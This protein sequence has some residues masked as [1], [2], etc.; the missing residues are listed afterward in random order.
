MISVAS[1]MKQYFMCE[2]KMQFE[3]FGYQFSKLENVANT[4]L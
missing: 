2:S 4:D 3:Q 1:I